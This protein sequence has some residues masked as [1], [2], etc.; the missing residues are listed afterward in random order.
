MV[1]ENTDS[2]TIGDYRSR[3]GS[4]L[5]NQGQIDWVALANT[6]V[7]ASV[8]LLSWMYGA[9][10]DPFTVAVA[11][12]V[13]A[14][15]Q[16]SRLGIHRLETAINNL[17]H[18]SMLGEV[19]WF[20]FGIN[21]VI[22]NLMHTTEG[23][24]CVMLC[25]VLSESRN[26]VLSARVLFELT[27]TYS[28]SSPEATRLTPSLQQWEALVKTCAGCLSSTPFGTVVDEIVMLVQKNSSPR[29]GHRRHVGNPKEVASVLERSG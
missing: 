6:T 1:T 25:S 9:G 19:L 26:S 23:A 22:R 24:T 2:I 17:G 3:A 10:I 4:G 20:G 12:A 14:K 27:A 29:G 5:P 8:G 11:Q 16:M 21:H 18:T 13:A 28:S 15:F 7:S